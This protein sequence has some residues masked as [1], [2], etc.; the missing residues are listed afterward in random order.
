M[1]EREVI[2]IGGGPAGATAGRELAR[3]RIETV[4]LEAERFPRFHIGESFLP[5]TQDLLTS[6]GLA[7]RVADLPRTCKLGAEFIMGHG[8]EPASEIRFADGLGS[9]GDESFNIARADFDRILL[10]AAGD[11]GAEVRQGRK[12]CRIL[13]LQ[14]GRV[15]VE[16]DDGVRWGARHLIDASGQAAV[17]GRHLGLRMVLPNH[18]KVAFFA[19]F[20]G[21][22]R[23]P[24]DRE[25]FITVVMCDEGWFWIIPLDDHRTSVGLVLDQAAAKATGVAPRHMLE[26]GIDRCPE[27]RDR[28]AGARRL[29]ESGS[30]ADFSYRCRPYAGQGYTLIGDAALF[31]DPVF[32]T[33]VCL[34]MMS[35]VE[36]AAGLAKVFGGT[37]RPEVYRRRY[38]R[39]VDRSSAVFFK[40][41]A[42]FYDP[43]FRDLFLEAEG[44]FD[45]HRAT[46]GVLAGSVFPRPE[47][48]L[49][50]RLLL[51]DLAV[52]THRRVA[53]APRRKGFSLIA[54]DGC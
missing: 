19:H 43:A 50:W 53:L 29:G 2:V 3:H 26:W 33:G 22:W 32:S 37:L 16:T 5:R 4:V 21:V 18:R 35:A 34:G 23:H 49:R 42:H 9:A 51:L 15:E 47:W 24:G 36:A 8:D 38:I 1:I 54:A 28:C 30:M 7:D 31:L 10:E 14:E 52:A 39:F 40:L 20:E 41:V 44:P 46:I 48:A 13:H 25:G 12:V 11:S 27:L 17:V 45:I 6:L